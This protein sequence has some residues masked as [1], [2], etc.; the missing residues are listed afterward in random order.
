MVFVGAPQEAEVFQGFAPEKKVQ[1]YTTKDTL[2]L[3]RVI[4]GAKLVIC[5]QSLALAIAH[6]LFKPVI[7]ECW[8]K[9]PNCEFQRPNTVYCR[10]GKELEA[11]L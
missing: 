10:T 1:Y 3:A 7:T 11:M 5:N 9:N 6:G 4:A 2:A 8:P